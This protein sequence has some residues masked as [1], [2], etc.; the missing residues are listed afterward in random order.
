MGSWPGQMASVL[1]H[2]PTHW[3]VHLASTSKSEVTVEVKMSESTARALAQAE[4]SRL[5]ALNPGRS[6]LPDDVGSAVLAILGSAAAIQRAKERN[7]DLDQQGV[8]DLVDGEV[9]AARAGRP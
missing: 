6:D 3:V 7:A 2:S 1:R 9:N 8:M 4:H 5:A